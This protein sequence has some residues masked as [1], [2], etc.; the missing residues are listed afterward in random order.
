MYVFEN[1]PGHGWLGV[2]VNEIND[3]GIANDISHYSYFDQ[4]NGIVWLEEDCDAAR[5]LI[6]KVGTNDASSLIAWMDINTIDKHVNH[7]SRIR[8]LPRFN[9]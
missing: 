5:F 2:P 3:L 9:A 1:D 4:K 8:N 6:A 7:D